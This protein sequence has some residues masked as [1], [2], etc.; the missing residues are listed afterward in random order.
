MRSYIHTMDAVA[1]N[2]F[3]LHA[4]LPR[5]LAATLRGVGVEAIRKAEQR[6]RERERLK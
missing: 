1:A 3:A 2:Q 6:A 5:R 4:A